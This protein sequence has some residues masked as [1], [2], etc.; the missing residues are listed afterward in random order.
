V[1]VL[2]VIQIQMNS[3]NTRMDVPQ[4]GSDNYDLRVRETLMTYL[5]A[6]LP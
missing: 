2:P 6:G 1:P 4:P 5:G 3:A